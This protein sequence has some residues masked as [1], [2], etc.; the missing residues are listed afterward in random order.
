MKRYLI[1]LIMA[2]A[3]IEAQA[4]HTGY[5][6]AVSI[7][8]HPWHPFRQSRQHNGGPFASQ[9]EIYSRAGMSINDANVLSI[10]DIG[11]DCQMA[12]LNNVNIS[13]GVVAEKTLL[14]GLAAKQFVRFGFSWSSW[15]VY[16]QAY[17][18]LIGMP[19]TWEY[20]LGVEYH[21]IAL[22]I[23]V[24]NESSIAVDSPRPFLFTISTSFHVPC[25]HIF[26]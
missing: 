22:Q 14:A 19:D 17:Y 15:G 7:A 1:F 13:Y 2:F 26:P 12:I 3:V 10:W 23:G 16:A 4:Q 11:A 24:N 8:E 5:P 9:L 25:L 20:A 18:N 6:V 21:S